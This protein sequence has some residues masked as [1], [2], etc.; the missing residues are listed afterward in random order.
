MKSMFALTKKELNKFLFSTIG[1]LFTSIF[2]GLI[3][4]NLWV[5]HGG[6]NIFDSGYA[7]LSPFFDCAPW[8]LIV[9]VPVISARS[10][11]EERKEGTLEW[12][13]SKPIRTLELIM[14]KFLGVFLIL[15]INLAL[16][17]IYVGCL[18]FLV[19][20]T[21]TLD[22]G[23][24]IGGYLGLLLLGLLFCSVGVF[25]SSISKQQTS[26]LLKGVLINLILY[27]GIDTIRVL[28]KS[29][30]FLHKFSAKYHYEQVSR[31]VLE[32]SSVSYFILLTGLLIIGT[33]LGLEKLRDQP[34]NG[35]TLFINLGIL[36][37]ITS[38][39]YLGNQ[40]IDLT[41]DKR[42]SLSQISKDILQKIDSKL[43]I[44]VFL[45]GKLP[46]NFQNLKRET[47][48]ILNSYKKENKE[49]EYQFI[50]AFKSKYISAKTYD[51]LEQLGI[52]SLAISREIEGITQT[53]SLVPWAVIHYNDKSI[54]VPILQ[55][56]LEYSEQENIQ[57]A[58]NGLEYQFSEAIK[59]LSTTPTKTVGILK[60]NNQ[61]KDI[62]I[63]SYLQE[64]RKYY[65]IQP[66][67]L[68]TLNPEKTQEKL[69][70][71]DLLVNAQPKKKFS[72]I[73]QFLIDQHL[74]YG[75]SQLHLID[76][77]QIA[78]DSLF[79]SSKL[80]AL[81]WENPSGLDSQFFS[82]GI[83]MN[84]SLIEDFYSE[85][86]MLAK[87]N[88]NNT[89]LSSFSWGYSNLSYN[90][91]YH[92]ITKNSTPVKFEFCTSIDTLKSITKKTILLKS[93]A[94]TRLKKTPSVLDLQ[95]AT[96]DKR[97]K[98][99][100]SKIYPLAVLLEN[101]FKSAY[102]NKVIPFE[103]K[104]FKKQTAEGK[105]LVVSDGDIIKNEIK[106]NYP[107]PLGF[108]PLSKKN[109][110]NANFLIRATH[111]LLKENTLINLKSKNNILPSIDLEHLTR[112][113]TYWKWLCV[114]FPLVIFWVL[115]LIA[116]LLR[117][118]RYRK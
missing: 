14:G 113:K 77:V 88:A 109:Y 41:K 7:S 9:L 106:N 21:Q 47:S 83:R 20:P 111:Y 105:L 66:I 33:Y 116:N 48:E 117:Y 64:L 6:F 76:K 73:Q 8:F 35:K 97:R 34:I 4:L 81:T 52:K 51:E 54:K 37:G 46:E 3:G 93:S 25:V 72:E 114:L 32:S 58:I 90:N 18:Y 31:G 98:T 44:E 67:V 92:P 80:T 50:S 89:Q 96:I 91:P 24:I 1:V 42:Y 23:M 53:Q 30:W 29:S 84:T 61:L 69:L 63:A 107:L 75:K 115:T 78:K 36:L 49:L 101:D 27:I 99:F 100:F 5:I 56:K 65:Y 102:I 85:P 59:M 60:G 70:K 68:D 45:E 28:E 17:S 2:L 26:A 39:G 71:A 10:F 86:I 104:N 118:Y 95:E 94:L 22:W 19:K 74:M 57:F 15:F 11:S 55:P 87:G 38:I 43:T 62:E 12:L 108:D 79:N 112:T 13:F 103:H 110:G 40:R 82:Y 16:T